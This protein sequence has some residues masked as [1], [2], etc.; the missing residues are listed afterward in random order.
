MGGL[1]RNL[2]LSCQPSPSVRSFND[3]GTLLQSSLAPRPARAHAI[4]TTN[5]RRDVAI[6]HLRPCHFH[7]Q[8]E[9]RDILRDIARDAQAQGSL[10][11]GRACGHDRQGAALNP[12][13]ELLVEVGMAGTDRLDLALEAIRQHLHVVAHHA[14]HPL[15]IRRG[16]FLR[17][18]IQSPGHFA[19]AHGRRLRRR[20]HGLHLDTDRHQLALV[21]LVDDDGGMSGDVGGA[22]RCVMQEH[23]VF[24]AVDYLVTQYIE[25]GD[26]DS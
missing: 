22:A 25:Q 16:L 19:D 3:R 20:G 15:R 21:G 11:H 8:E 9:R 4:G 6:T 7:R 17:Q 12:A 24:H 10:A 23:Q 1:P 14:A 26:R 5:P 18:R 2:R 13:I